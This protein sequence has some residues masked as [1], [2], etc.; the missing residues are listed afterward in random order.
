MTELKRLYTDRTDLGVTNPVTQPIP[1]L[2]TGQVLMKI[3]RLALTANNIT[4]AAFGDTPHLRY[5]D[6]FPTGDKGWGQMPAWG[7]AEV[8]TSTV[9]GVEVGERYYGF[10]PLATHLVMTPVRVSERGFYDGTPHRLG[11]VSAYNQYQR[12]T[13]DAAYRPEN[14][15]YQML[16]RPLFI[17]SFMLADFLEDNAFFGARRIIFSSASSK[18][19]YGTAFCLDNQKGLDIV[20]LTSSGNRAFVDSLGCYSRALDY[21]DLETLDAAV[22]TLYVD[23]SGIAEV[24]A[25][26]HHHFMNTLMH[27][28]F[29]GSA[30]SQEHISSQDQNLPGPEPKT[31]FAPNQIKKR[32]TD[33]G[34]AEV[35]RRF[36]EAQLAFIQRISDP[37]KPWMTVE[38]H[39]G[40]ESAQPLIRDLVSG[41]VDPQVG[42]VIVME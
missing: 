25:R 29:A 36:N 26:I 24:R 6:F 3:A 37:R 1:A 15:D 38:A 34:P 9:E 5:W 10:W 16:V 32:N 30:N 7:F 8:V 40:L 31:Y 11:L 39:R 19:A 18:T 28:C 20:G 33:W 35:T 21:A 23:F 14:E 4:Y 41:R 27:D 22:P 13:T 17:T 42:H 2:E 12:V